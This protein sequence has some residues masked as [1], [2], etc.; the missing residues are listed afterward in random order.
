M[1]TTLVF[2]FDKSTKLVKRIIF[3]LL[4]FFPFLFFFF[5]FHFYIFRGF[6]FSA[7]F[8]PF[9]SFVLI[10]FFFLFFFFLPHCQSYFIY[11]GGKKYKS[12]AFIIEFF[13]IV[14]QASPRMSQLSI[15]IR[16]KWEFGE[17]RIGE[18]RALISRGAAVIARDA[19]NEPDDTISPV[20]EA[21]G[22]VAPK[23]RNDLARYTIH[24]Y[25]YIYILPRYSPWQSK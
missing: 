9:I 2:H 13:P 22:I 24:V 23:K 25:I 8:F 4:F 6:Y 21:R 12:T 15:A 7:S 11:S 10:F 17:F 20:S 5:Y 16:A 19:S 14:F 1:Y 3:S 18:G